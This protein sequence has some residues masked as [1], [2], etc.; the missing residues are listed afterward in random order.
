MIASLRKRSIVFLLIILALA[1]LAGTKLFLG[2]DSAAPPAQ[3][4]NAPPVTV[5]TALSRTVTDFNE[6]TGQFAPVDY[7][8]MR[9]RVGGYLTEVH[10]TDGQMVEK[11]DLLFVIDPRPFEI[12]LA[13]ARAR[14]DQA[15]S[16]RD[17]ASRQLTRAG[18]LQR[19]DYLAQS[20]LE[21]RQS[22]SRGAGAGADAARAAV[23]DA[24]LNLQFTRI[25]APISGRV[26]AR[27]I[28][29]GNLVSAG[30]SSGPGTLLTTIVSLDPIY[31]NFDMSE[32]DFL[33]FQRMQGGTPAGE[34]NVPV[35]LR[36]MDEKNWPRQGALTFL[37]NQINRSSGT[38]RA[39]ATVP[40]PDLMI[41]PGAFGRL[42]LPISAPY[43]AL[44][45][46]DSAVITD[47]NRKILMTVTDDGTVAPKVVELGPISDGLRV[48]KSGLTAADR[49]IIN[50]L[51]RA[52][53]GA[54]VTAQ[55]GTIDSPAQSAQPAK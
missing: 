23:R 7:V 48:V 36:L 45:V 10:F 38:I 51:L 25:T 26:S 55:P 27:Q 15:A 28:S 47:Q 22:E 18:E 49:V 9:A 19:R 44:L 46:P 24:E 29:V 4:G 35:S 6:L 21:Q 8:E 20:T 34:L 14:L 5:A 32:A 33:A 43:S 2:R 50:G 42:R 54:K 41:A 40:N 1:V 17:F 39:R 16:S 11:G 31:F 30:G 53:P 12:A 13:S 3:A 37:D 52:R